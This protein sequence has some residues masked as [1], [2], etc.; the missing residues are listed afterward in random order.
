M[1]VLKPALE[2]LDAIISNVETA[3][4][5]GSDVNK[6]GNEASATEQKER[7]NAPIGKEKKKK[8]EKKPKQPRQPSL[9]IEVT[10]FLQCDLRVGKVTDVKGHPESEKLYV[11]QISYGNNEIKTVC[12]GMREFLS[13]EE[14]QDRMVV[15]ICNL[16]PRKLRGI[17]SEA[18]VLAGSCK[19]ESGEKE[20]VIPLSPPEEVDEGSIVCVQDMDGERTVTEGKYVSGK[21]WDKVVPRLQVTQGFACYNGKPLVVG[22][23]KVRCEISDG[24]EIH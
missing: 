13:E 9:P 5:A 21:T 23:G 24:A 16:K 11:L 20:T 19:S 17:A 6:N 14:M 4:K 22:E 18:M 3:L 10:Q 1:D 7:G 8:K 15:T 2:S 12:A